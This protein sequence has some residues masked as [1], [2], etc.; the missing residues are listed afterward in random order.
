MTRRR[1]NLI[2]EIEA[3]EDVLEATREAEHNRARLKARVGDPKATPE[4][5][6]MM[7][8]EAEYQEE[9]LKRARTRLERAIYRRQNPRPLNV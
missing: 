4:V 5:S 3:R 9:K 6:N 7:E 8:Q 1:S 2:D